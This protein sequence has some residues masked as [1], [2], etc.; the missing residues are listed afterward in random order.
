MKAGAPSAHTMTAATASGMT[1]LHPREIRRY[2]TQAKTA[3]MTAVRGYPY[4]KMSRFISRLNDLRHA[5]GGV[6]N[7]RPGQIRAEHQLELAGRSRQPVLL[8]PDR[9]LLLKINID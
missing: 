5:I 4:F 2:T 7:G 6:E 1:S 3:S 8:V 9:S